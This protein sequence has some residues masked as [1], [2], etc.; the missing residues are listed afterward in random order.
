[1]V[2][3]WFSSVKWYWYVIA[4]LLLFQGWKYLDNK[5][6]QNALK[7]QHQEEIAVL[8]DA[9]EH[10]ITLKLDREKQI[11]SISNNVKTEIRYLQKKDQTLKTQSQIIKIKRD[12]VESFIN[13]ASEQL[14]DSILRAK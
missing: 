2:W 3:T 13:S 11:D 8:N 9:L 10:Q 7:K 1:M 12:E 5:W 14:L 6:Q 4:V